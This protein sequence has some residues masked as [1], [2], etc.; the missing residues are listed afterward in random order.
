MTGATPPNVYAYRS[1]VGVNSTT[2]MSA[3]YSAGA[4]AY[5]VPA[6]VLDPRDSQQ[7]HGARDLALEDRRGAVH[8]A[9]TAGHQAVQV[10]P[11]DQG[12]AGP[13][14]YRRDDVAAGEDAAVDVH[15]GAV[16]H[17]VDDTGQHLERRGRAVELAA[18]VVGHDDGVGTGVDDGA[19]VGDGLDPL[20]HQGSGPR[21]PDPR[22]VVEPRGGVEHLRDQLRDRALEAV[23]R[24]ELQGLGRQQVEPPRRVQAPS[25]SVRADRAG[26][27][28][29]PLRSSR[30]RRPG[31][32]VSTVRTSAS[33][34][35]AR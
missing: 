24:R 16:A 15:L 19:R 35:A 27:I 3:T 33:Y 21:G 2:S 6:E 12:R 25:T 31:T 30:S 11:A 29:S 13:E 32:G 10:G 14:G 4:Q 9:F 34:P 22:Q 26:G 8:A 28:V 1:R 17:R 5:T 23:E 7:R 18:T 20:D